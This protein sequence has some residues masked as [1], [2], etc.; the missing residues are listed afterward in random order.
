MTNS[1]DSSSIHS[2]TIGIMCTGLRNMA[3]I[4]DKAVAQAAVSGPNLA[5]LLEARLHP[6]MFNLLQQL[7]YMS[8]LSVE[9]ARYFA[10]TPP[11][12]VGYDETTWEE[13]RQSLDRAGVYLASVPVEKLTAQAD[14]MVPTFMDERKVMTLLDYAAKVIVPDFYFHMVVAYGLLRQN[15]IGIGKSDYLGTI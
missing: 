13:L 3:K 10:D 2:L 7:Q 14:Q 1:P 12:R 4:M 5:E 11:P 9:F 15:G 6:D 8:F